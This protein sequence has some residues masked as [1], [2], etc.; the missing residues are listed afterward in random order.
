MRHKAELDETRILVGNIVKHMDNGGITR[1]QAV[2]AINKLILDLVLVCEA[3][4]KG[5][6]K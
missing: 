1:S 4:T 2:V 6:K 5:E 3:D